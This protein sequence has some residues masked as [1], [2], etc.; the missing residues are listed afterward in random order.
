MINE[1]SIVNLEVLKM[2]SGYHELKTSLTN[3][4]SK[5]L[6]AV[7]TSLKSQSFLVFV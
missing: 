5:A 3:S 2:S 4:S 6:K 7:Y 1:K